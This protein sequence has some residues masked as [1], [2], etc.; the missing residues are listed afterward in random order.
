MELAVRKDLVC[1]RM[2]KP[3]YPHY[4]LLIEYFL[5][6]KKSLKDINH[7]I[8]DFSTIMDGVV[9]L[10]QEDLNIRGKEYLDWEYENVE[11]LK[12]RLNRLLEN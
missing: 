5:K 11:D 3:T 10:T 4:K 9:F 7:F 8:S 6:S 12:I 1:V 2:Y